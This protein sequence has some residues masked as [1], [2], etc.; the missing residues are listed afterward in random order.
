MFYFLSPHPISDSSEVVLQFFALNF[1]FHIFPIS[2]SE[3][4]LFLCC[5]PSFNSH[6]LALIV[7]TSLLNA[8]LSQG[9]CLN[10]GRNQRGLSDLRR[11]S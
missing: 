6:Y 1:S 9:L 10:A 3:Q 4:N 11:G 8:K 7:L 2:S 5:L